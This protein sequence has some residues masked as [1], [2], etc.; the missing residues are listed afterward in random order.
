[1]KKKS[2]PKETVDALIIHLL[3]NGHSYREIQ[4]IFKDIKN[5]TYPSLGYIS[6]FLNTKKNKTNPARM[7]AFNIL[8]YALK[9]GFLVR[10]KDCEHCGVE[11]VSG[12][13]GHH[14]LGYEKPIDVT[15]LCH[16]CH[17]KAENLPEKKK[18]A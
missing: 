3:D 18:K 12:T 9:Q 7:K 16:G 14:H 6:N 10:R 15:W 11:P 4:D 13:E 2:F 5:Y 1:M 17:R 8:R